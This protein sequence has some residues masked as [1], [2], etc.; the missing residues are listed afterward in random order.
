MRTGDV[1]NVIELEVLLAENCDYLQSCVSVL[2]FNRLA[3]ET[4]R[5]A[6]RR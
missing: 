2:S 4:G 5:S 6:E 3:D 1:I